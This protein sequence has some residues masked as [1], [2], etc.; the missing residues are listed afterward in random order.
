MIAHIPSR[1]ICVLIVFQGQLRSEVVNAMVHPGP[2]GGWFKF[3]TYKVLQLHRSS[4]AGVGKAE[5]VK[6]T[7]WALTSLPPWVPPCPTELSLPSYFSS[8]G[9]STADILEL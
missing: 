7:V 4:D 3:G 9:P 6:E 5:R 2:K 1:V 8:S